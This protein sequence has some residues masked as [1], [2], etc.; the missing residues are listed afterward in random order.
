MDLSTY[1]YRSRRPD[2]ATLRKRIREI[3]ETRMRYGYRRIHVLL[4]REGWQINHKRTRRLYREEGLQL[5]N[6]NRNGKWL[7][8]CGRIACGDGTQRVLG[9]GLHVDQLFDGRKLRVLTI[10]DIFTSSAR[11][12]ALAMPTRS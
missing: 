1:H 4:R 12:S 2:Q 6:K 5:R 8:S 10:V 11:R 9:D 3:A 7:P